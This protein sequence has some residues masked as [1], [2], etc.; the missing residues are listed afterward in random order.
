MAVSNR[1]TSFASNC[2][3]LCWRGTNTSI[4]IQSKKATK[5]VRQKK[6]F[7][8]GMDGGFFTCVAQELTEHQ[9]TLTFQYN[10]KPSKSL[11]YGRRFRW[12]R[13]IIVYDF[14]D[15]VFDEAIVFFFVGVVPDFVVGFSCVIVTGSQCTTFCSK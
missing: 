3:M 1:A 12:K 6:P 15:D 4:V 14:F 9:L 11:S 2:R 5:A 8:M 13:S 10:K 7:E